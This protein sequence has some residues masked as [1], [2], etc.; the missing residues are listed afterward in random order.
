MST[1][2]TTTVSEPTPTPETVPTPA[3]QETGET[4]EISAES[5][6]TQ[7]EGGEKQV[8]AKKE[9]TV[10]ELL[11]ALKAKD[12]RIDKL[13]GRLRSTER[14][15]P[16]PQ[17]PIGGTNEAAADDSEEL[18]LKRSELQ[19]I[20]DEETRKRAPV[21]A[22]QQAE[23]E[24]R[25]EVVK[26]LATELGQAQFDDLARRLDVAVDGLIDQH[27]RPKP[28]TEA[29]FA[30]GKLAGAVIAYLADPDNDDEAEAI[31]RMNAVQAGMAIGEIKAKIAAR[32]AKP[33][34]SKAAA[35]IEPVKSAGQLTKPI[36]DL[37]GDEFDK[38]RREYRKAHR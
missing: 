13:T 33:E 16:L 2:E 24:R 38:R 27:G 23:Y 9:P 4:G 7:A 5:G 36:W 37:D 29:I 17:G 19:R 35:V 32:K 22:Q 21:Y 12:K 34:P 11:K 1:E 6:E 15:A 8:E 30:T 10:E 14:A 26:G 28:A 31:G 3:P 18:T 20:L 25:H